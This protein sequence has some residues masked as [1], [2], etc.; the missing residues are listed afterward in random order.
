[1]AE[2]LPRADNYHFSAVR[3]ADGVEFEHD[4][5]VGPAEASY[6]VEVAEMAGVPGAVVDRAGR[7]LEEESDPPAPTGSEGSAP[8]AA[9]TDGGREAIAAELDSVDLAETTPLEAL[10][11]LSRL[12]SKLE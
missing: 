4:L 10:N 5:R 6:G 11:L 3:T 8:E 9:S 2:T 1:M 7:L 12:Q